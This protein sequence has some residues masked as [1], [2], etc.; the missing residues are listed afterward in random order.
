M[1]TQDFGSASDVA[2]IALHLL[3]ALTKARQEPSDGSASLARASGQDVKTHAVR[4]LQLEL[5]H[6]LVGGRVGQTRLPETRA[7]G[8]KSSGFDGNPDCK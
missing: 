8:F 6:V 1:R 4:K 3:D 2:H 7:N 5:D